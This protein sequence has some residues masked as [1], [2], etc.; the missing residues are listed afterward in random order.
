LLKERLKLR[1]WFQ[2]EKQSALASLLTQS[3]GWN[4]KRAYLVIEL[5]GYSHRY[6]PSQMSNAFVNDLKAFVGCLLALNLTDRILFWDSNKVETESAIFDLGGRKKQVSSIEIPH[7]INNAIASP[8]LSTIFEAIGNDEHFYSCLLAMR[9]IFSDKKN[10]NLRLSVQWYFDAVTSSDDITSYVQATIA[11]ESLYGDSEDSNDIGIGALL[12]NRF[13]YSTATTKYMRDLKISEF[14]RL[15]KIRCKIVHS[16]KNSLNTK[17]RSDSQ[18]LRLF[19]AE[20]ISVESGYRVF[21]DT[22]STMMLRDQP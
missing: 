13:A 12:A 20:A 7:A 6:E 22:A 17:E 10:Q 21:P 2:F 18:T 19:C 11:M 14:K 1:K 16:G 4:S 5:D 3:N 8:Q 15:Y 9:R